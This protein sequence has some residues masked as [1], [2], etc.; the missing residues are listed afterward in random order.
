MSVSA[1]SRPRR[2]RGL[3]AGL[4]AGAM[5]LALSAPALAVEAR[6]QAGSGQL[7]DAA[8]IG[9]VL[10]DSASPENPD[11]SGG[12]LTLQTSAQS[13]TMQY[14]LTG[15]ALDLDVATPYWIEG[16][17]RFDS[18]SQAAGWWRAP[19]TLGIRV[20]NGVMATL[21][22][23]RDLI[24]IRQGDNTLGQ[25]IAV[26]TD[27]DFHTYRLEMHGSSAG[28]LVRVYQDG[29]LVLSD[30]A[31]WDTTS[32]AIVFWGES[33]TLA[34]GRHQ[35]TEVATNLAAVPEPTTAALWL[36]GLGLMAARARR[37]A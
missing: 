19:A 33:S 5:G 22:I 15:T 18:G 30:N 14:S 27:D 7:P 28:S 1:S 11:L 34:T 13:E 32:S 24:F 26:D 12:V 4:C 16:T 36:A 23:R 8:G 25:Q 17:M 37:R 3:S 9:W 21:D 10:T 2:L 35:W 29:L 31:A 6:W 20:A